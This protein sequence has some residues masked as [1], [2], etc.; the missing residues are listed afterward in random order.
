MGLKSFEDKLIERQYINLPYAGQITALL[1]CYL[2]GKN[3]L[4]LTAEFDTLIKK[5]QDEYRRSGTAADREILVRALVGVE[6]PKAPL[7][8]AIKM[9]YAEHGLLGEYAQNLTDKYTCTEEI[10]AQEPFV[11]KNNQSFITGHREE[12]QRRQVA[13][14]TNPE[15]NDSLPIFAQLLDDAYANSTS[16]IGD[17]IKNIVAAW[18]TTTQAFCGHINALNKDKDTDYSISE[19]AIYE[20]QRKERSDLHLRTM[21]LLRSTFELSEEQELKL[22]RIVS[23]HKQIDLKKL[24]AKNDSGALVTALEEGC[25][26]PADY[27]R[28]W[29][30]HG[31]QLINWR[32]GTKMQEPND[33]LK[34]IALTLPE[35]VKKDNRISQGMLDDVYRQITGRPI[36]IEEVL[37]KAKKAGNPG[38]KLFQLLTGDQGEKGIIEFKPDDF[39]P[40]MNKENPRR[41]SVDRYT[42]HKMRTVDKVVKGGPIFEQ[43]AKAIMAIITP[44]IKALHGY[45]IAPAQYAECIEV[46]T[47]IKSVDNLI[48]QMNKGEIHAGDVLRLTRDRRN[49]SQTQFKEQTN[50]Q[51]SISAFENG[52]PAQHV[53]AQRYAEWLKLNSEQTRDFV[54]KATSQGTD[55]ATTQKPQDIMTKI[56]EGMISKVEGLRTL[57]RLSG[58]TRE[59]LS[60]L[61]GVGMEQ[62]E[63]AC[64]E[65]S[66]GLLHCDNLEK[67]RRLAKR[68]G[69]GNQE[70]SDIFTP[71]NR[72]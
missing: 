53:T 46:L 31:L 8:E 12:L 38:G 14:R 50:S 62:I 51:T 45:D 26:M 33:A 37:E 1:D 10:L 21:R 61:T 40:A 55:K 20:W 48:I 67:V 68:L 7:F 11:G 63:Y 22:W 19:T 34:F 24:L 13:A 23:G 66:G 58:R 2:D 36:T 59:Q 5:V 32:S 27:M 9:V 71:S 56:A 16:S 15:G 69:V 64:K 29:F 65:R 25:G 18:Q 70:F 60:E 43:D 4:L 52:G 41:G 44:R 72:Y 30:K 28:E 49:I 35:F 17:F 3:S 54:A 42:L 47:G 6:K 57:I 39:L